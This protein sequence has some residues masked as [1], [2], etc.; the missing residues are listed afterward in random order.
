MH[1]ARIVPPSTAPVI[2]RPTY[3]H[4]LVCSAGAYVPPA[5]RTT[6]HN[7][8]ASGQADEQALLRRVKGLLNKLAEANMQR[9]AAEVEQ[10]MQ[11]G[12]RRV[13]ADAI[14]AELLQ[15]GL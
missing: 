4:L 15:V 9:T 13:V 1:Y 11:Q 8:A 10:L 12:S 2:L 5:L 3:A 14:T 6:P 7:W